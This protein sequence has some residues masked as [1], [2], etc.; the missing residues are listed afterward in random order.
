M[1]STT[2]ALIADLISHKIVDN[3]VFWLLF[4]VV[5]GLSS[6][7]ASVLKA[8]GSRRGEQM[9]TKA[10]FNDL[11]QR[12]QVTTRLTEEIRSE[13]GHIEW[14]M[15]ET[16]TTRRAKLE[17]FVQQIGTVSSTIDTW[18]SRMLVGDDFVAPDSECLNRLEMLARLYFPALYAP[19]MAFSLAWRNTIQH[20]LAAAQALSQ[21]DRGDHPA[22]L[23]QMK[24]N[25][26]DYKPLYQ[27]ALAQRVILE[28]TVVTAMEDVL[29]L[30][31]EPRRDRQS[32]E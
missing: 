26:R 29:Q 19:T 3:W 6:L 32:G 9:A 12:L 18:V 11:K 20:A 1:D 23:E 25:L 31:D 30:P 13:V 16:Y 22:R 27:E 15:R 14:R 8:Y 24:E 2:Q 5:S 17:E 28:R 10:D 7:A 21:I 4:F